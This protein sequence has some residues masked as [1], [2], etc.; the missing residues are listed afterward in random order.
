MKRLSVFILLFSV[1]VALAQQGDDVEVPLKEGNNAADKLENAAGSDEGELRLEEPLLDP[2]EEAQKRP[3]RKKKEKLDFKE[4]KDDLSDISELG[5]F[6]PFSDIAVIQRRY[7]PKTSRFEFFPSV[8]AMVN[9]PF[10][11]NSMIGLRLG[12]NLTEKWGIEANFGY[13]MPA[14]QRITKDLESDKQIFTSSFIIPEMFFGADLRWSPIYG[15]MSFFNSSIV[16]F[17]MYFSAGGGIT[18]TNQDTSPMTIHLGTGQIFALSKGVAARWDVSAYMYNSSTSVPEDG[19]QEGSFVDL[20]V[21]LGMSFF[22]P[23]ASYR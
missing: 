19:A 10:F 5:N 14:R 2:I 4:D 15:K 18:T 3:P 7:L 23:E 16:P 6:A 1:S 9:N 21:S 11:F 20:Y 17:D 13:I 22:F 12:Y 8:G